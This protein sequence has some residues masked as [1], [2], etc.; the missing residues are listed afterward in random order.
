MQSDVEGRTEGAQGGWNAQ[1]SMQA[2]EGVAC[3]R[4]VIELKMAFQASCLA[5]FSNP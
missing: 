1:I 4:G 2:Q 3:C 5:K